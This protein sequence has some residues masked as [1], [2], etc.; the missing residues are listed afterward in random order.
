MQFPA[1]RFFKVS[2][3]ISDALTWLSVS[4]STGMDIQARP[5]QANDGALHTLCAKRRRAS[6]T[7]ALPL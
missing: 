2:A 1:A 4:V 3:S 7:T 5:R 6:A